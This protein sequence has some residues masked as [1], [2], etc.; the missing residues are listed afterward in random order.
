MIMSGA[1]QQAGAFIVIPLRWG[2]IQV[3]LLKSPPI[4][5]FMIELNLAIYLFASIPVKL[6]QNMKIILLKI[7]ASNSFLTIQISR[8]Q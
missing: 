1:A 2:E 5:K 8:S 6:S 3:V 7:L 4:K